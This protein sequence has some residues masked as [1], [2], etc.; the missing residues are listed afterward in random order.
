[1]KILISAHV[2]WWNASAYYAVTAAQALQRRGHDVTLLAHHFTPGYRQAKNRGLNVIGNINLLSK[3]P[4]SF[5]E[6]MVSLADKIGV[7]DFDVFNPHRP[8]DHLFLALM[9]KRLSRAPVLIRTISDVRYPKGNVIN[10]LLHERW[11]DAVIYCAECCFRRYISRFALAHLPQRVIYS[12]LDVK[13]FS[14]G[15]WQGGNR[16]FEL[17]APRIVIVARLSPNKGHH[18]LIEAASRVLREIG[19]ASFIVVGKE[20]EVKIADLQGQV[21]R[22]GMEEFFT[23]T[24]MLDDPRPAIAAADIGVVSSTDSEVISRATQEF[25]AF[26]VPV[27]ASRV[28]VLPEMVED[29]VNGILFEPGDAAGLA[30]GILRLA[31]SERLHQAC[32][33]RAYQ[34]ALEVHDL[35]VLGEQTEEFFLQVLHDRRAI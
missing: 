16:F 21:R 20:E 24:G 33:R 22:L 2:V 1:M 31:G 29:G 12:A 18:T 32:S 9:K 3:N 5:V 14:A 28:N 27:V 30:E 13:S 34:R 7:Q 35:D 4:V 19:A 25:F 6:N 8:E 11:T 23:F 17:D 26:G 15:D 10:R